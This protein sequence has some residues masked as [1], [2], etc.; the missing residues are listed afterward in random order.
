MLSIVKRMSNIVAYIIH[1]VFF[2]LI[3]YRTSSLLSGYFTALPVTSQPRTGACSSDVT[4]LS[5][6]PRP[7]PQ[8]IAASNEFIGA[9]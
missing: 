9:H 7:E 3:I 6:A 1:E 4:R 8:R 5:V 2:F